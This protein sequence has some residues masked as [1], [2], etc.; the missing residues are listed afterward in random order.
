M[1][2]LLL[3]RNMIISSPCKK[4]AAQKLKS[5]RNICVGKVV[6][7][8]SYLEGDKTLWL[9]RVQC[10]LKD[11]SGNYG[12]VFDGRILHETTDEKGKIY[13]DTVV[14]RSFQDVRGLQFSLATHA[15]RCLTRVRKNGVWVY[16]L[17]HVGRL[18]RFGLNENDNKN[19]K[20][21][22]HP[23]TNLNFGFQLGLE[24][25]A[26][27]TS[28]FVAKCVQVV[29]QWV[30]MLN[31]PCRHV[32]VDGKVIQSNASEPEYLRVDVVSKSLDVVNDMYANVALEQLAANKAGTRISLVSKTMG[33]GCYM[34][35][36][37]CADAIAKT[38]SCKTK[39]CRRL[40]L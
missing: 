25:C 3:E 5:I 12:N 38:E 2:P 33:S 24:T 14:D 29:L 10:L 17:H 18:R 31:L 22:I 20:D 1:G 28:D 39:N 27:I 9:V 19:S 13:I 8:P 6:L 40:V 35:V 11:P 16:T 36:Y 30:K 4:T 21:V 7:Y 23:N 37:A 34:I 15:S 32:V 26:G